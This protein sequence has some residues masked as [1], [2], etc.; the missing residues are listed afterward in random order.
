MGLNNSE[1][2]GSLYVTGSVTASLGFSGSFDIDET[3]LNHDNLS[4]FVANEHIDH[5]TVSI[6]GTGG[7]TGGG[8]ITTN[9]SLTLNT[10]DSQFT[11]GVLTYINTL[12]VL[13]GS[14]PTYATTGSNTFSGNQIVSGN[15]LPAVTDTYDLGATG[16]QWRDLFLSSGSLYING[17]QV[18]S[19]D[20]SDMLV[21]TDGGESFKILETAND[22]ITLE[23]ANGDITFTTSGTG[24]IE[25][26]AP[27]QVAAGKKILSSDGNG[28]HFGHDL[29]VTGSISSTGD[30]TAYA[31]SDERLKSN[32]QSIP[33]AIGKVKEIKG[34]SFDWNEKSNKQGHDVG[35]IAQDIE[36]V[37]P[38]LVVTRENGFKAVKYDRLVALLIQANKELID[39][40]EKLENK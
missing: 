37:L 10:S 12:G 3:T 32:I 25:L 15:I 36:K 24:N 34:V 22:T 39:R 13:S 29:I 14:I 31:T 40:I 6:T 17:I 11:G 7:V 8:D 4:G 26:D 1:F 21:Q 18:L 23:T 38:E 9:R 27:V 16:S 30:I 20:G 2:S 5:S 28:V 19:T 35:V 33:N